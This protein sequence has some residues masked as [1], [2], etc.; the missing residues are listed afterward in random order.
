MDPSRMPLAFM[1]RPGGVTGGTI[2]SEFRRSSHVFKATSAPVPV[3][4][5]TIASVARTSHGSMT[6]SISS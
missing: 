1:V 3:Q 6:I 2:Y 5:P 4:S